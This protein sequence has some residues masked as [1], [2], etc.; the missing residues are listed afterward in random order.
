M[1]NAG[2]WRMF[3]ATAVLIQ[4]RKYH[5]LC[6]AARRS[7]RKGILGGRQAVAKPW[8]IPGRLMGGA[9]QSRDCAGDRQ[10]VQQQQDCVAAPGP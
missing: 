5:I 2:R 4:Q 9:V 1:A 3:V 6:C 7:I 8:S 10:R